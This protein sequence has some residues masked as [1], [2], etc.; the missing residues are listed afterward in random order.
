MSS[1]LFWQKITTHIREFTLED[2]DYINENFSLC[3]KQS[4]LDYVSQEYNITNPILN[5]SL[6]HIVPSVKRQLI[7]LS[8][9]YAETEFE[10][11]LFAIAS[12]IFSTWSVE[13]HQALG[14]SQ[15]TTTEDVSDDFGDI[16]LF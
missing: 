2:I 16:E 6:L 3:T 11:L 8:Y 1:Y 7:I 13:L 14:N 4:L 12:Y 5:I 9:E 15:F 10:D